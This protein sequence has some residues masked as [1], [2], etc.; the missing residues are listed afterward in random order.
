MALEPE[1]RPQRNQAYPTRV[2]RLPLDVTFDLY[3]QPSMSAY[4]FL[5]KSGEYLRV[6]DGHDASPTT[7]RTWAEAIRYAKQQGVVAFIVN[8]GNKHVYFPAHSGGVSPPAPDGG[9]SWY[10]AAAIPHPSLEEFNHAEAVPYE[11]LADGSQPK[12]KQ[13]SGAQNRKRYGD[14]PSRKR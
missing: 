1:E 3:A 11:P 13:A 2:V 5:H 12:R 14:P 8:F 4:R 9:M 10:I 6:S 7:V